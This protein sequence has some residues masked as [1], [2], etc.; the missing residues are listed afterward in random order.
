MAN[1]LAT[2]V[3]PNQPHF[4]NCTSLTEMHK[5]TAI[6]SSKPEGKGRI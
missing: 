3:G 1:S 5:I 2:N 4:E 6:F